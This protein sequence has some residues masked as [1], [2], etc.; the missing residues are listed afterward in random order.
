MDSSKI[1]SFVGLL[2]D[3]FLRDFTP[4]LD[5]TPGSFAMLLLHTSAE[6]PNNDIAPW[7]VSL[8][9]IS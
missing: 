8:T 6:D 1:S 3:G 7:C 9:T 5:M 4:M 2:S